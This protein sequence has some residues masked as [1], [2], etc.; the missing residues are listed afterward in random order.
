M[1][2]NKKQIKISDRETLGWTV[3]SSTAIPRYLARNFLELGFS[4]LK[5][6][7]E[8]NKSLGSDLQSVG[9]SWDEL[10]ALCP[11][12]ACK[13]FCERR[14][15]PR[16]RYTTSNPFPKWH[17]TQKGFFK[18]TRIWSGSWISQISPRKLNWALQVTQ[19]I[20]CHLLKLLGA[21]GWKTPHE[22]TGFLPF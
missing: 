5:G 12:R 6:T 8:I 9:W 15:S 10:P 11:E 7:S 2:N 22:L 18:K 16:K 17:K 21:R 3:I 14:M 20:I 1:T 19:Q 13:L 4:D